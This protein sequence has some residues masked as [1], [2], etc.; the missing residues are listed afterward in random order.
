[1][2]RF[3]FILELFLVLEGFDEGLLG[4]V[5]G[6]RDIPDD[7]EDL[8]K[9]PPQIIGNKAILPLDQLQAGLGD[10]AHRA[11][12]DYSHGSYSDDAKTRKTWT[13]NN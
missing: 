4:Q 9:N 10:F 11:R 5:L 7:T 3:L 8:Y 6:I 13:P 12:N 2:G 1:M